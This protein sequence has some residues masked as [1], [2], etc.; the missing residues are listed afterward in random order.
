MA[1]EDLSRAED[2]LRSRDN[3][4]AAEQDAQKARLAQVD[5][6]L[7]KTEDDLLQAQT[8]ERLAAQDLAGAQ[9]ALEREEGET[10]A[11][12]GRTQRRPAAQ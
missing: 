12:G 5:T 10:E 4:L 8:E 6:R 1:I 7:A 9:A 2:L 3:V 11:R